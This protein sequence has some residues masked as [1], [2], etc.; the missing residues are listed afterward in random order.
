MTEPIKRIITPVPVKPDGQE[1]INSVLPDQPVLDDTLGQDDL[2]IKL[3]CEVT[4]RHVTYCKE[5]MDAKLVAALAPEFRG[6]LAAALEHCVK[7]MVKV[8]ATRI[9]VALNE[10]VIEPVKQVKT[11]RTS[12]KMPTVPLDAAG[13]IELA[14]PSAPLPTPPKS[15]PDFP[16]ILPSP[17]PPPP[18]APETK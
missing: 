2:R 15:D 12:A 16:D 18:P 5:D 8:I 10:P 4:G 17:P 1:N 9:N 13:L 6:A 7:T 3:T 11:T 14:N